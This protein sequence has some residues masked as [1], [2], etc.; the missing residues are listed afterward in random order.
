MLRAIDIHLAWGEEE[1]GDK[2][3]EQQR[4]GGA[5]FNRAIMTAYSSLSIR[6][7]DGATMRAALRIS[8]EKS[9]IIGQAC[10]GQIKLSLERAK[11]F[12]RD[13][14]FFFSTFVY[15]GARRADPRAHG[16]APLII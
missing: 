4:R 5:D 15:T 2:K 3:K 8:P 14:A 7:A 1:E 16:P 10:P 11:S 12:S 13:A 6:R 9:F